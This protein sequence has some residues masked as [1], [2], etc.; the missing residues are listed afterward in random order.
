MF[1]G[2]QADV[3]TDEKGRAGGRFE[4]RTETFELSVLV[5]HEQPSKNDR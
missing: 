1:E 2:Q 5:I 4:G 3:S